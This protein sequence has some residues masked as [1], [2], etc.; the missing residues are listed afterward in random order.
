MEKIVRI[1]FVC[2]PY[3]VHAAR[4]IS[5]LAGSGWD[6][7]IF[8]AQEFDDLHVRF[9]DV[10]YWP[11]KPQAFIP[12]SGV[13]VNAESPG[14]Q[15]RARGDLSHSEY[16][17]CVLEEGGFD[18][19]HSMEFQHAGYLTFDALDGLQRHRPTWIATNYGS[20][21]YLYRHLPTHAARIR[22]IL[23]RCD[24]YSAECNRDIGM[25]RDMGFAGRLFEVCPNSGGIDISQIASFRSRIPPSRRK[26]IA[27]KGYEHF[28]GRAL[29]VLQVLRTLVTLLRPYRIV[30]YAPSATVR[31][32]ADALRTWTGLDIQCYAEQET[33]EKILTLHGQSRISIA[34]SIS[35]GISTSLLEAMAMGSF[36]IQSGTACADEW[37]VHG[38]TGYV[39]DPEDASSIKAAIQ[40]ALQ[41]DTL[42]DRAAVLN[43][44]V[45]RERADSRKVRDRIVRAYC[46]VT[47][48]SLPA[49]PPIA[50]LEPEPF[51]GAVGTDSSATVT[52]SDLEAR[53]KTRSDTGFLERPLPPLRLPVRSASDR[54]V[55]TVITPT[56][57]RADFLPETIASVLAQDFR[58]YEYLIFDD[59]SQ[60]NTTEVVKTFDD[61]RIRYF[62]HPNCGETRTVNRALLQMAGDFFTIVNSDDPAVPGAFT[63]ML[64]ALEAAPDAL[65]AYPDWY[66]V[67]EK[68]RITKTI[69]LIDYDMAALLTNGSVAIGPGAMFR[70]SAIESVGLRDPLIRFGA[71]LD[72]IYRLALCGRMVHVPRLLGTHREHVGSGSIAGRSER[73][74]LERLYPYQVYA[75]HPLLGRSMMRLQREAFAVGSFA[76]AMVTP[77]PR[78]AVQLLARGFLAQPTAMLRRIGEHV[79]RDLVSRLEELGCTRNPQANAWLLKALGSPSRQAAVHATLRAV[80]TDPIGTL[81]TAMAIGIPELSQ[82]IRVMGSNSHAETLARIRRRLASAGAAAAVTVGTPSSSGVAPAQRTAMRMGVSVRSMLRQAAL[83]VPAVQRL[84]AEFLRLAREHSELIA[85]TAAITR[86]RD[87]LMGELAAAAQERNELLRSLPQQSDLE[88]FCARLS[89]QLTLLSSEIKALQPG[90][91]GGDNDR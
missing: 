39:T 19:V 50:E 59:G 60:D 81:E 38:E 31:D 9:N 58:D 27:I 35:D 44:R 90:R 71:D 72:F 87:R 61:P 45:I 62:R 43:E 65:L 48:V 28:A 25:A 21:I 18:V 85:S 79:P 15:A 1:I 33:H 37:I 36:P 75:R 20:D 34:N 70:G 41:N 82:M 32:A 63:G 69:R 46:Q 73:L 16:L 14:L 74:A 51:D 42:V 2:F 54:P 53:P 6:I 88:L 64:S 55:L 10:T 52:A 57:N 4:W 23:E 47:G 84:Y 66:V 17:R 49:L 86:E 11:A 29:L 76:A 5:L 8:P 80:L 3:S 67:D 91:A 26:V 68:S 24:Y 7:H 12:R 13:R 83:R 22:A 30:V 77:D 40:A 56:Y 78:L 89:G